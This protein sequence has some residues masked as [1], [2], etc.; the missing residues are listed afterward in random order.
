MTTDRTKVTSGWLFMTASALGLSESDLS[1]VL[2]VRPDSIRKL[3][4]F[5]NQPVPEGVRREMETFVQFTDA[6]V[7]VLV[8]RA[9]DVTHPAMIVYPGLRDVPEGHMAAQYGVTWWDHVAFSTHKAVPELYVGNLA[10]VAATYHYTDVLA[11]NHDPSVLA[12][13]GKTG[14]ARTNPT[15]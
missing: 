3:W 8:S 11:A 6:C 10:E 4:K 15:P 1:Y 9:E 12:L 13:F 14:R 2:D 7:D 5:G